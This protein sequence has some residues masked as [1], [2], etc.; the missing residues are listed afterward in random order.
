MCPRSRWCSSGIDVFPCGIGQCLSCFAHGARTP[1][2]NFHNRVNIT[3]ISL[4][5]RSNAV[6][7]TAAWSGTTTSWSED[8]MPTKD[9]DEIDDD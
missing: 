8:A 3:L 1:L 4:S 6:V 7:P 9:R 5:D 2:S